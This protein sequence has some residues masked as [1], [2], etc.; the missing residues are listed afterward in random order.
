MQLEK[1][2]QSNDVQRVGYSQ[3]WT[4][5]HGEDLRMD[6]MNEQANKFEWNDRQVDAEYL[7]LN[8]HGDVYKHIVQLLN[9]TLQT[10]DVFVSGFNLIQGLFGDPR[11]YNLCK[12]EA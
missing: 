6:S 7:A 8:Q 9:T 2:K 12:G 5:G 4:Q 1:S 10:D 11:V 3:G